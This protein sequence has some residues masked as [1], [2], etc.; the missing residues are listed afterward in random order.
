M[1][2]QFLKGKPGTL[3]LTIYENNRPLI[4]TSANVTLYTPNGAVLQAETAVTAINGTN[5]EMTY[6]LT[7][8]HTA[9][10]DL[11]YKAEFAYV[12]SGTTYYEKVLF[13][14]VKSILSIPIVDEDLFDELDSLR[15]IA[16]QATG[17]ATGGTLGTLIDTTRR[18]EADSFWKGGVLKI[19]SGVGANQ[20]R[21]IT[22][23]TQSSSTFD[24]YPNFVTLPDT[25]SVYHV[26]KSFTNKIKNCFD[27]LETMIANKGKRADLILESSQIA[28]P[29]KYL[30]IHFICLDLIQEESDRWSILAGQYWD[31]FKEAFSTMAVEYDSDESG[32]VDSEEEQRGISSLEIGRA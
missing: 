5:G 4:P 1:K 11:N 10:N 8:T 14:V 23:F 22:G 18:K 7:T 25:T 2:Q 13:D 16:K 3:K 24:V 21:D 15:D 20:E 28:I 12:Y 31:K 26:I 27:K 17:T 19:I 32:A 30:T 6:S 29:L 9:D